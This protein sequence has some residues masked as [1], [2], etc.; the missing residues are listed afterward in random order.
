MATQSSAVTPQSPP[1]LSE[2]QRLFEMQRFYEMRHRFTTQ[3]YHQMIDAGVFTEDDR[4]ELLEGEVVAISPINPRHSGTVNRTARLFNVLFGDR[5]IVGVQ[6]PIQLSEYSEPQPDVTLLAPH[7]DF[8]AQGHPQPADILLV[9]EVAD[10][11]LAYDR[12]VKGRL[13]AQAGI[14]EYWLVNLEEGWVEIYR[15]PSE[16]GYRL[17][18]RALPGE[19][20]HLLAFPDTAVEVDEIL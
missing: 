8:Y 17:A 5:A 16:R 6:N 11:S 9:V 12:E 7:P 14:G 3:K 10:A 18:R 2:R 19:T 1:R 4:L 20:I 13:Y 15:D